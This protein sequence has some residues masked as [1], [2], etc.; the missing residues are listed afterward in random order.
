MYDFPVKRMKTM[1]KATISIAL[2]IFCA[3]SGAQT[4][5][6]IA[7]DANIETG[8]FPNGL[9]YYIV[10]NRASRG[11]ADY[12]VVQKVPLERQT[13]SEALKS[14]PILQGSSPAR[15]LAS[16]GVGYSEDGYFKSDGTS[17]SFRFEN[18]PIADA[19]ASD[20]TLM[21]LFGLCDYS[22]YEQAV[23]ISGDVDASNLKGKMS[24]FSMMVPPRKPAPAR[25]PYKW[26]SESGVK[27]ESSLVPDGSTATISLTYRTPRIPSDLA[28][29]VQVFA[30]RKMFDELAI[31]LRNHVGAAFRGKGIA[32]GGINTRYVDS[33]AS[34]GDESFTVEVTVNG[35]E[36][37]EALSVLAGVLHGI[38]TEGVSPEE[39]KSI[40]KEHLAGQIRICDD[41]LQTNVGYISQCESAYL[42]GTHLGSIQAS[43]NF[44]E[45]KVLPVD[46]ESSL[47]SSFTSALI[48]PDKDVT[49]RIASPGNPFPGEEMTAIYKEAWK[50][51]VKYSPFRYPAP[52][53]P[54]SVSEK[55]KLKT[56]ALEPMT[57][58]T[59]WTFSNGMKVIFKEQPAAKELH[60][61][62]LIKGGYADVKGL[63][64][65]EG[66]FI[67][68]F[69]RYLRIGNLPA[70]EFENALRAEGISINCR[71]G[72]SDLRVYGTAPSERIEQLLNALN[73]LAGAREADEDGY[74]YYKKCEAIRL[75]VSRQY[76]AVVDSISR[77]D[78]AFIPKKQS[79]GLTGTLPESA[80]NYLDRQ[81]SK[82]NDGVLVIMGNLRPDD[83][84]KTLTRHLGAFSTGR[85]Y[86]IRPDI[87]YT[88]RPGWKSYVFDYP[89]NSVNV[90]LTAELPV[91]FKRYMAFR[92][93]QLVFQRELASTLIRYGMWSEYAA[94]VESVPKERFSFLVTCRP[95]DSFGLPDG[96]GVKSLQATLPAI[97]ASLEMVTFKT[98]APAEMNIYKTILKSQWDTDS[99]MNASMMEALML[100]YSEGKDLTSNYAEVIASLTPEDVSEV[101]HAF[102][103]GF[104]VEFMVR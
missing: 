91:T 43:V 51:G 77:P 70:G 13:A 8:V 10:T 104:K 32:L 29:T 78:Y 62:L 2:T 81:F 59:M 103:E 9:T 89:D 33:I 47:L 95:A 85:S 37:R 36:V 19:A 63:S 68:D 56:E 86:S 44:F 84:K 1:K 26:I 11:Y 64:G 99:K 22:P 83:L 52:L 3:L 5:P 50:S 16:K 92:V 53:Q 71:A 101:L 67:S 65:G 38:D 4:L 88:S 57:G 27:Y 41:V 24:I 48:N 35:S 40:Q 76:L 102:N 34:S 55:V 61:A 66:P 21:M 69:T 82:V 75:D 45:A 74:L 7:K 42:Y 39:M 97:R 58:G 60:Y 18:V 46:V 20:T 93:A 28:G 98:I 80:L 14:L 100:R 25:E 96:V 87:R 6:Q 94:D 15:Y 54:Y 12:A 90:Y 23:I 73:T 79:H 72:I 31:V 49:L 30:M 17:S